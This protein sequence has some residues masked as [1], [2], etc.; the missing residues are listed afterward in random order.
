MPQIR[1]QIS[2][3]FWMHPTIW[4]FFLLH[5]YHLKSW[6]FKFH[7]FLAFP[8]S[9]PFQPLQ[10]NGAN[11]RSCS[12]HTCWALREMTQATDTWK[13]TIFKYS[14]LTI[15]HKPCEKKQAIM[16]LF[17]ASFQGASCSFCWA[18]KAEP[19]LHIFKLNKSKLPF[20]SHVQHLSCWML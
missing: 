18:A 7:L 19:A 4:P 9:L 10:T 16:Y 17:L 6:T 14:E 1:H 13:S 15:V 12:S 8:L 20:I 11:Q 5:A 2:C 3:L